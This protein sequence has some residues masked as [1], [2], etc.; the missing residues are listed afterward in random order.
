MHATHTHAVSKG[1]CSAHKV[2]RFCSSRSTTTLP[3]T[4]SIASH[5]PTPVPPSNTQKQVFLLQATN[6]NLRRRFPHHTPQTARFCFA[7]RRTQHS[8]AMSHPPQHVLRKSHSHTV[9]IQCPFSAHTVPI[10]VPIGKHHSAHYFS[11]EK[12]R[13]LTSSFS[14][15]KSN[16]H[17]GVYQWAL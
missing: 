6:E 3:H 4:K 11:H 10:T 14:Q 12:R 9:P 15:M 8:L 1:G 13:V 5:T 17:C 2:H 16:G 7:S